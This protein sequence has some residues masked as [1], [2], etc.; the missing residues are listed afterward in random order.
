MEEVVAGLDIGTTAIKLVLFGQRGVIHTGRID[1]SGIRENGKEFEP[2]KIIRDIESLVSTAA[3]QH[4]DTI[5]TAMGI[6]AFFP[7]FIALD[8]QGNALTNLISWMD[9]RGSKIVSRYKKEQKD[10]HLLREKTGCVVHESSTLWKILW[11]QEERPEIFYKTGKFLT[12][13]DFVTCRLC[14]KYSI[15]YPAASA[16]A[17]FNIQSLR[18]DYKILQI[19]GITRSQ[20]SR[21]HPVFHKEKILKKNTSRMG[22]SEHAVMILGAGDGHLSNVGCGCISGRTLCSTIGTSSA[23]RILRGSPV[24]RPQ[25]WSHYFDHDTYVSGIATN[26]GA[27]TLAWVRNAICQGISDST[28]SAIDTTDL[29]CPSDLIV[30]PFFDGER[31]PGYHQNMSAVISGIRSGCRDSDIYAAAIEGILF[32]LFDCYRILIQDTGE[33]E[34]IVATGGYINSEKMLQMQADIFNMKIKVP[35]S[36]E[37]S[38]VGAAMVCLVAM[39]KK[40][41]LSDF[42]VIY[43]KVYYPDVTRHKKYRKKYQKY[44]DAYEM[45]IQK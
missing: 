23:L 7:G 36:H 31:G 22:L 45:A 43:E 14:G 41:N 29:S 37:A 24:Q 38:A 28:F 44:R 1:H 40:K 32:N 6:S 18:W 21:C 39:G 9:P 4:R 20:L 30:L 16:T 27:G 19:A 2:E 11:L 8:N 13:S 5:I 26:A 42:P 15:S 3:E 35:A 12:L 33:P 17:L 10:T 25:V 34:E